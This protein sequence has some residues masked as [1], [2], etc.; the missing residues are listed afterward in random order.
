MSQLNFLEK[1]G[2]FVI[3][4]PFAVVGLSC[5][6]AIISIP[7]AWVA[8]ILWG[9]FVTPFWGGSV[10][11]MLT[12]YGVALLVGV[13]HP[14]PI[15]GPKEKEMSAGKAF[16]SVILQPFMAL[17]LGWLARWIFA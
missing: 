15:N 8:Q 9:W 13:I 7:R 16:F 12:I 6:A 2:V 5:M 1:T 10:P 11:P 17:G 3:G 14:N 4:A